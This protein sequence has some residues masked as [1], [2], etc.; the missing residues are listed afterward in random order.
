M[1]PMGPLVLLCVLATLALAACGADP[2]LPRS[3]LAAGAGDVLAAL[4]DAPRGVALHDGTRLSTCVARARGDADLQAVGAALTTAADRLAG[5]LAR[6]GAAAFQ[7]GYLI[8]AVERGAAH[9]GGVGSQ[10]T[11][12]MREAAALDGA[13]PGRRTALL[14][15]R[16]AGR[17]GG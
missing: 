1:P 11:S 2:P 12:R 7:L 17:I 14:R 16:A 13:P 15:G 10:L 3:C 9:T 6:S 4:H 5:R 8:G